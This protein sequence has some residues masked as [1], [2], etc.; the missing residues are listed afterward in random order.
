MLSLSGILV[1]RKFSTWFRFDRLFAL[2]SKAAGCR[3]LDTVGSFNIGHDAGH[4]LSAGTDNLSNLEP[5][6]GAA[7]RLL[8][9][10]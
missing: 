5:A 4:S 6:V 8:F 7:Y 2:F 9:C 3:A 10:G 1:V